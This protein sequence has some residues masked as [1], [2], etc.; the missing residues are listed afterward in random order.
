MSYIQTP[1]LAESDFFSIIVTHLPTQKTV[2]FKGWV[3]EFSDNFKSNWNSQ[4]VYGRMDPLVTFQNTQRQIQLGF[5]VVAASVQEAVDQLANVNQLIRFLYPVY[6]S[7]SSRRT[8]QNVLKAAP[9]LG[10]KWT[11]LIGDANGTGGSHLVG[12][13][14]GVNYAPD[15]SAG[16]FVAA[17]QGPF[18]MTTDVTGI[19][20]TN[21]QTAERRPAIE[22]GE[23]SDLAGPTSQM[24][25]SLGFRGDRSMTGTKEVFKYDFSQKAFVPK[26][27]NI[28]F[29]FTVLHTHLGG[30]YKGS[31]GNWNFGGDKVGARFP[32]SHYIRTEGPVT[33]TNYSL[34]DKNGNGRIDD[35]EIQVV[36][37]ET[38]GAP[39]TI[40]V[41]PLVKNLE[42]DVLAGD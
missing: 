23:G 27:L 9:L 34:R 16:G 20:S 29:N 14:G 10:L 37:T 30:W 41:E 2:T 28:S 25:T 12:H 13:A 5:D 38:F 32:N 42:D 3:T 17:Q 8:A 22:R 15:I 4:T 24:G 36:A 1:R 18:V 33:I 21:A 26:K 31:D 19:V 6:S 35:D 11:N 40:S 7:R 39:S